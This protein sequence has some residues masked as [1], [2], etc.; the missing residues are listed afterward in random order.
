[1]SELSFLFRA[2]KTNVGDWY[3]PPFRYFQFKPFL[4]GD[5]LDQKFNLNSSKTV[6][7]GGGGLGQ[8]FFQS[9]L[10]RLEK[11]NRHYNLIGWGVGIDFHTEQQELLKKSSHELYGDYFNRFDD[12]GIRVFSEK[13]KFEY[14]PCASCMSELFH[15]YRD[16]KPSNGIGVYSHKRRLILDD[17]D[18]K[19]SNLLHC[20]NDGSD[21]E[22]KLEFLSS[23]E[24]IITNS[25]H[26]V[27]WGMLLNRKVVI[28]PFK[29]GLLS[30]KYQPVASY[31]EVVDDSILDKAF[32]KDN[33]LEE[34]RT[35]NV[36]FYSKLA[37]NYNLL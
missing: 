20:T 12:V 29:T 19:K 28:L 16:Q 21:F 34:C 8:P 30:F 2:D 27:Y 4:V 9:H 7:V 23:H 3:C 18:A 37:S 26:G 11:E 1:M 24:Y 25:Y 36:N 33:Y 10:D 15:K 6:I 32:Y 31:D 35:L 22:A 5:I 14:I 17:E 13:Q